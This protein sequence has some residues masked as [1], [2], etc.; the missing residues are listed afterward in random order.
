MLL[1]GFFFLSPKRTHSLGFQSSS[2]IIYVYTY[3]CGTLSVCCF[4]VWYVINMED[5]ETFLILHCLVA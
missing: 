5:F 4:L 2:D 1:T 3:I